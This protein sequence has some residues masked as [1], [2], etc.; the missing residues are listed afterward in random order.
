MYARIKKNPKYFNPKPD[1]TCDTD[2]TLIAKIF[3]LQPPG[4]NVDLTRVAIVER[5]I[6]KDGELKAFEL[7]FSNND[8]VM[9]GSGITITVPAELVEVL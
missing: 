2:V 3:N 6:F 5:R 4:S 9:S 7:F 1:G 8:R